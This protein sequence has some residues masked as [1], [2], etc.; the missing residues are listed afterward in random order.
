MSFLKTFFA[1]FQLIGFEALLTLVLLFVVVLFLHT[2]GVP[3]WL[4]ICAPLWMMALD[5]RLK[6]VADTQRDGVG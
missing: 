1:P 4:L 3:E 5:T 6:I 2:L